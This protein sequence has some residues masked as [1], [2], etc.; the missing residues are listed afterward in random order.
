MLGKKSLLSMITVFGLV[1]SLGA[2]GNFTLDLNEELDHN[3]KLIE[4]HKKTIEMLEKRNKFLQAEKAKNPKLYQKKAL[5]E[6]TDSEY[7]HRVKLNGAEAKNVSFVIKDHRLSIEM[8]I[9][10][11]QKRDQGYFASSQYFF[12]SYSIPE[13]VN[14]SKIRH[15]VDGDYFVI[16]MPKK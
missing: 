16:V 15:E 6:E 12:Q 1:S 14:E 4:K 7:I 2:F 10:T 13:N 9:K 11:E 8:N 5:Y 3:A